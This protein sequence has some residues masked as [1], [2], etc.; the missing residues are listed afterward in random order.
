[1][2]PFIEDPSTSLTPNK[3]IAEKVLKTQLALFSKRPDMREDTVR[4]HD[5]LVLRG[6]VKKEAELLPEERA[7]VDKLPGPGY[8]IPWRIVHNEGP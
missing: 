3:Y 1:M 8:F 7:V 2:L 4:S 5:K 6:P